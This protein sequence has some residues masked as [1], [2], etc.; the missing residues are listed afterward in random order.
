M[1]TIEPFGELTL[2]V[3]EIRDGAI[4]WQAVSVTA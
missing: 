2:G 1:R 4:V 3:V